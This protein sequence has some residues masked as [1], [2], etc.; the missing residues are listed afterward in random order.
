MRRLIFSY[1][2]HLRIA[3]TERRSSVDLCYWPISTPAA[4]ANGSLHEGVLSA[5]MGPK[6]A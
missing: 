5:N 3:S 4:L 2:G 6:Q 1:W